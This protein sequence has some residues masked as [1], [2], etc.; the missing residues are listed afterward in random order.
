ME[1]CLLFA[2]DPAC[3]VLPG[4]S[5]KIALP[6]EDETMSKMPA[7]EWENGTDFAVNGYRFTMDYQHGG[8][9]IKSE[10]ERFLLMKAPNFLEHYTTLDPEACRTVLELGVYQ[11]GSFVFLDQLLR[12]E[13]ISAVELTGT[14]IPALDAYVANSGGRARVHYS[15]SQDD[16]EALRNIVRHDLG[17]RLDLVVDDASHWYKQTKASFQTLFPLLRPG[18]MYIIEDWCWSFQEDFQAPTHDWFAIES[19]ANLII[20]LM[21]DMTRGNL[22]R[23]VQVTRELIKI[24][25][26]DVAEG[27]V[28]AT[29]GRRGRDYHPI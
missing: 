18:G 20:D 16:V 1:R 23:D 14:P 11:G 2:Q 28:F 15:T 17:G 19:P 8:S 25:R 7:I 5:G 6:Q 29:Q 21:E 12:P 13:K 10:R 3:K 24:L 22:I 27:Q 9:Q 4:S 26:S